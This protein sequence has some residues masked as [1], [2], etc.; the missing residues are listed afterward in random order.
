MYPIFLGD[1][2]QPQLKGRPVSSISQGQGQKSQREREGAFGR[3]SFFD[4]QIV[5]PSLRTRKPVVSSSFRTKQVFFVVDT[6]QGTNISHLGKR[7]IIFKHAL[8]VEMLFLPRPI[9]AD[10]S[11]TGKLMPKIQSY[12][13]HPIFWSYQQTPQCF[14]FPAVDR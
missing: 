6:L 14:F 2:F 7:N 1:S 12:L 8:G 9:R 10:N 4:F 11:T 13:L 5:I 3:R